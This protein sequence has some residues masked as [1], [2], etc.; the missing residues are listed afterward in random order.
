MK[1]LLLILIIT[2]VSINSTNAQQANKQ[3]GGCVGYWGNAETECS[4]PSGIC[5]LGTV[6]VTPRIIDLKLL[7]EWIQ[8]ANHEKIKELAKSGRLTKAIGEKIASI[9]LWP[10]IILGLSNS[11]M[12]L[13]KITFPPN[14]K[15]RKTIEALVKKI[16]NKVSK[17]HDYV[18]HVTLLR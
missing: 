1:K 14:A 18:G 17:K 8:T 16:S 9:G 5:C 4:A 2:I 10:E 6:V 13:E 15:A 7:D 11:S 12:I 3:S